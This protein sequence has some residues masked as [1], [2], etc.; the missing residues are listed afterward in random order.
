MRM[1]PLLAAAVCGVVLVSA[2]VAQAPSDAVDR[3]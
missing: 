1:K 2:L 3:G